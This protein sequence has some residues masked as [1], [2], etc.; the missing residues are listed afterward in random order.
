MIEDLFNGLP[1][2]A[3]YMEAK[4]LNTEGCLFLAETVLE[5]AS[6]VYLNTAK[7]IAKH[8][9]QVDEKLLEHLQMQRRFFRSE[10]YA[11]LCMGAISGDDV[12]KN[13]DDIAGLKEEMLCGSA[14]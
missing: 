8:R 4:D 5:E 14:M 3:D 13:L 6:R 12:I 11:T 1:R 2:M 10:Y 7:E 9:G